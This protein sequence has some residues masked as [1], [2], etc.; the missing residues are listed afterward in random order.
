MEDG[1]PFPRP[2]ARAKDKKAAVLEPI[3]LVAKAKI[4]AAP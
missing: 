1:Q 2:N 3:R 4:G